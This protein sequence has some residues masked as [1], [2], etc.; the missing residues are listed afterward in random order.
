MADRF[1]VRASGPGYDWLPAWCVVDTV[2]QVR[3]SAYDS[4]ED[5]RAHAAEL[6]AAEKEPSGGDV[7]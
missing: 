2:K 3:A 5:A 6:N 4:E 7:S 1:V